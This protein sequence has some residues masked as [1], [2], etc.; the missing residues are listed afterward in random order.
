L[1]LEINTTEDRNQQLTK[2]NLQLVQRWMEKMNSEADKMNE[3]TEFYETAIQ[4]KAAARRHQKEH[5]KGGGSVKGG[6][7][8]LV[9]PDHPYQTLVSIPPSPNPI[10]F[11]SEMKQLTVSLFL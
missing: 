8:M 3:A 9:L 5:Q 1:Q 4:K 10:L 11:F 2:E 7:S 6:G